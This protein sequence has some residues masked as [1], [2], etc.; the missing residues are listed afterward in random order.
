MYLFTNSR[1]VTNPTMKRNTIAIL[2]FMAMMLP[3]SAQVYK[4]LDVTNGL[5]DRRVLS[6]QKDSI[7]YMWLLTYTGIDRFDGNKFNHY[8]LQSEQGYISF[9]SEKNILK[10]DTKGRIWTVSPH[11][12][13]FH[14]DPLKDDFKEIPL[15]HNIK[16]ETIEL[17]EMTDHD[18]I[19]F[20]HPDNQYKYDIHN[21][22]LKKIALWHHHKHITSIYQNKDKTYFIGTEEGICHVHLKGDTLYPIHTLNTQGAFN[23]PRTIYHHE[24]SN[25]LIAYSQADGMLV[26]DLTFDQIEYTFPQ[27]KDFPVT[28]LCAY[29]NNQILVPTRGAGVYLYNLTNGKLKRLF[30]AVNNEPNK[31]NGN[32]IRTLYMD[33]DKRIWM[34]VY[35]NGITVYDKN[36]PSYK[37]Y[38]NYIGN[39][40]SLKNDQVNHIIEDSEG[41]IWFATSNGISIYSPQSGQW[42]HLLTQSESADGEINHNH[43]FLSLCEVYPGIIIAGGYTTGVYRIDKKTKDIRL[44][45]SSHYQ[46][47]GNPNFVNKYIRVIYKDNEGL[48]WTGGNYYLG[49]TNDKTKNFQNYFIGNAVT[50]ILQKD[51][52]NLYIGTGNGIYLLNKLTHTVKRLRMPF[53][54]QHINAMYL[55]TNGDLY[56]GTTL[57]GLIQLKANGEYRIFDQSTS[58][59]LSDIITSILPKDENTL[60]LSTHRNITLF[61][62]SNA[63]FYNWGEDQGLLKAHFN[64]RA[65]LHTSR[66]TYIF[67]SG[68]GAIEFNDTVTLPRHY[69][70]QLMVDNILIENKQTSVY[71]SLRQDQYSNT[72]SIE[73]LHLN[74]D[75]NSLAFHISSI[76]YG[77]PQSTYLRCKLIGKNAYWTPVNRNNWIQLKN[78]PSGTYTLLLQNFSKENYCILNEK[79]VKITIAP[80]FWETGWGIFLHLLIAS[81]I[82][83][84]IFRYIQDKREKHLTQT[85]IRQFVEATYSQR[86][87]LSL[88]SASVQ[89]V[90]LGEQAQLAP[91]SYN[92]LQIAAYN[93][94]SLSQMATAILK[95]ELYQP[96]KKVHVTQH[97]L[98]Q[99]LEFYIELMQPIARCHQ[100]NL[101]CEKNDKELLVWFDPKRV[102]VIIYNLMANLIVCTPPLSTVKLS[103]K[104]EKHSWSISMTNNNQ[105]IA[106]SPSG[107][108]KAHHQ[109]KSQLSHEL[110]IIRKMAKFHKGKLTS[111]THGTNGYTFFLTFP[112]K[113]PDYLIHNLGEPS[114]SPST[115]VVKPRWA[116]P[117]LELMPIDLSKRRDI[118]GHILLVDEDTATMA[119]LDNALCSDWEITTA[120]SVYTALELIREYEPDI[121][122]SGFSVTANGGN[123]LCTLLKSDMKTN[124]IP[125]IMLTADED[126][127]QLI[128]GNKLMAD[129][130]VSKP[131]DM[132]LI[133][134]ILSS[135]MDNHRHMQEH[136]NLKGLGRD[137]KEIRK[138][139]TELEEK[140]LSKLHRHIEQHIL[141]ER[142]N[143]DILCS[144]M[145][146]SRTSLHGKLKTLTNK[147]TGDI[148]RDIRMQKACEMLL[149]GEH[150]IMEVGE[151]LGFSEPKYFREIFKKHFGFSPSE[152]IKKQQMS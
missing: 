68:G 126:K 18:E 130:Y 75:E 29:T 151:L 149:S 106:N 108:D 4:Y 117:K 135:I 48:I 76:N 78:L 92:N 98:I 115:P 63:Q 52:A 144:L 140:F 111:V 105:A 121:I 3:A 93:A 145:G 30:K 56:I 57:S 10:T 34:S 97:N 35:P 5:S 71:T 80:S 96:D 82:I 142:F 32:D 67:G 107:N 7:G 9:Y 13:I 25:R 22:E 37:W 91:T 15:P 17:V 99:H 100:V 129:H 44:L 47:E 110:Q 40:N 49:C 59:L 152:Y 53:S 118:H 38:K 94:N 134:A 102:E 16:H 125:I 54:S 148:I 39:N 77:N 8:R 28:T 20:C 60:I 123:D 33:E 45:T 101:S 104:E 84:A 79:N 46:P 88:I 74:H 132:H 95:A 122:I 133:K 131:F 137:L 119:F 72:N 143:V 2:L 138:T 90:M 127:S 50:C 51:S 61:D 41:D 89:E 128:S 124:H 83:Y 85:R 81:I 150:T 24:K 86:A 31:M 21:N 65:A 36:Y 27:L 64:P 43:T 141:D 26:Y 11:G 58:T 42:E 146:M 66:G 23:T 103:C 73:H 109:D 62:I 147:N 120:Q 6:I 55:H 70:S 116:F 113:H 69:R 136:A 112:K 139:N 114:P 14:Y 12:N 87:S 1:C 19:W